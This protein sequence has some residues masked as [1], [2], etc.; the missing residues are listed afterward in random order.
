MEWISV[1]KELPKGRKR[2]LAKCRNG[3]IEDS[4]WSGIVD[5][6]FDP[7][8]GWARCESHDIKPVYVT[9]YCEY[10]EDINASL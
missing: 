5:V 9:H 7:H 1:E 3:L 8:I 6:Y 10:P 2:F 4:S